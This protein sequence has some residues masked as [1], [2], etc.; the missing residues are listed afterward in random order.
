[1][2]RSTDFQIASALQNLQCDL[3]FIKRAR[4]DEEAEG[5]M[6]VPDHRNLRHC[7]ASKQG[8]VIN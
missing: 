8:Q 3:L 5:R 4:N 7:K 2:M 1:M 6:P